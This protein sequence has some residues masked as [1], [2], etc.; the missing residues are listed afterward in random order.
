VALQGWGYVS[1]DV[2]ILQDG[3]EIGVAEGKSDASFGGFIEDLTKGVYTFSLWSD[4]AQGRR[5]RTYST[6]FWINDGTQTTVSDILLPPTIELDKK[7]VSAGEPVA[8]RGAS[9]PGAEIDVWFYPDK[10]D[11]AEA[12]ISKSRVVVSAT[13]G[14][15]LNLNTEGKTSGQYKVKAR[16]IKAEAGE[17]QFS[18]EMGLAIGASLEESGS[19]PGADLNQD[20]RVNIT[21]FSILLYHWGTANA[22][23]D[24]NGDG[25]V[26]LIDFSI[27]MYNW[28]G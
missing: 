16:V 5:S 9:A 1:Q 12:E 6:T 18:Q 26:N 24:Q 10:S 7:E 17:S 11:L 27:M 8:A 15:S 19:C 13:G 20:G 22:C 25:N 2:I 14:W 4:D 28:T 3:Q 21:D 23:A